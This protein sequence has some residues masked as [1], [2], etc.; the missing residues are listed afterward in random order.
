MEEVKVG[1]VV[2]FFAKPGVAAIVITDGVLKQ[3]DTI[4]IKGH[5]SDFTQKVESMQI[6][7][8]PVSE[9]KVGDDVGIKTE[10]RA[11]PGD[12]AYKVIES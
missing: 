1:E 8:Q 9:A 6:N 5:T 10:E 7:N 2:K 3:G 11:R 4:H 12:I